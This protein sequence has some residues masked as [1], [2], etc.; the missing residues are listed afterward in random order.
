M[1][2]RSFSLIF[3]ITPETSGTIKIVGNENSRRSFL[4]L[5]RYISEYTCIGT[6]KHITY[7]H[8][9]IHMYAH[10]YICIIVFPKSAQLIKVM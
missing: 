8:T 2:L 1:F 7:I 10:M 6:Y 3:I 4:L 5:F 9:S